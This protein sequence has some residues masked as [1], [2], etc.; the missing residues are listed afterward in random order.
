M[1][2]MTMMASG[3]LA[4]TAL[5]GCESHE[6]MDHHMMNANYMASGNYM[7]DSSAGNIMTTPEGR[8]VYTF[9][10]DAAGASSC[11]GECAEHWPPVT[12]AADAQPFGK[13]SIVDRTDGSR[14]W[15]YDGKPL[16]LYDDDDKPGDAEGDGEGGVWHVVK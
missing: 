10:K 15:A 2:L 16:Y 9:D 14:Q 6:G 1:R 13:M 7:H 4:A 5:A 3:F 11:Y 12:A 8:T